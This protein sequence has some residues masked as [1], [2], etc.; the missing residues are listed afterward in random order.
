MHAQQLSEEE[1]S[2][3]KPENKFLVLYNL[4]SRQYERF[5]RF[6]CSLGLGWPSPSTHGDD[7]SRTFQ[8]QV[9]PVFGIRYRLQHDESSPS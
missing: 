2:L 3:T 7:L 9:Q 5:W 6:F 4:Y 1:S 8:E